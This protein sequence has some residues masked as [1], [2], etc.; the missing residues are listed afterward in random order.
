V[1][2]SRGRNLGD[3]VLLGNYK[4]GFELRC[5]FC[6]KIWFNKTPNKTCS[7]EC[8]RELIRKQ[9]KENNPLSNLEIRERQRI[10]NGRPECREK[11]RKYTTEH[12]PMSNPEIKEKHK[13]KMKNNLSG[14]NNPLYTKPDALENLRKVAKSA[15]CRKA[16]SE[17]TKLSYKEGRHPMCFEENKLK[18]SISN[19]KPYTN[20]K[21][22]LEYCEAVNQ[23]TNRSLVKHKKNIKNYHLRGRKVGYQLDHKFSVIEGFLQKIDPKIIG[24]WKNLEILTSLDNQRKWKKCSINMETLLEEIKNCEET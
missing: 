3:H 5:K 7:E 18:V 16:K 20:S 15:E 22:Y 14:K 4:D 11:K 10:A 24:H 19:S 23:Q 17:S 21:N 13:L 2:T 12:N 9:M 1:I 8:Y 6:G